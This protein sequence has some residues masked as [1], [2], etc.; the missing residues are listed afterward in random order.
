MKIRPY[1][2]VFLLLVAVSFFLVSCDDSAI[3]SY[4]S[5]TVDAVIRIEGL[6]NSKHI[7]ADISVVSGAFYSISGTGPSNRTISRTVSATESSVQ[8]FSSLVPG[9]W[10]FEV[11]L[12]TKTG[13][14]ILKGRTQTTLSEASNEITVELTEVE[15]KGSLFLSASITGISTVPFAMTVDCCL[16]DRF[17][18][19]TDKT[20]EISSSGTGSVTFTDLASGYYELS[21]VLRDMGGYKVGGARETVRIISSL[22]SYG[23]VSIPV[24][25]QDAGEDES[26]KNAWVSMDVENSMT[27]TATFKLS[28][29]GNRL[30]PVFDKDVSSLVLSSCTYQWYEDGEKITGERNAS[31]I[32][33][34]TSGRWRY[35]LVISFADGSKSSAGMSIQF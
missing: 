31:F 21:L 9:L 4:T 22:Q 6:R 17:G 10:T 34:R 35:D 14:T 1:L 27:E 32:V 2:F 15:G 23:S 13:S 16:T 18:V 33:K 3:S 19:K 7:E 5:E 11:S 26:D 8:I 28:K 24:T 30:A 12:C 29:S 20:L 25:G